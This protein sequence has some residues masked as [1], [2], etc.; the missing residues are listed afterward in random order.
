VPTLAVRALD[1]GEV[2][3]GPLVPPTRLT[4]PRDRPP[5]IFLLVR[6]LRL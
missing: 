5:P 4:P 2:G 6:S 1:V 3:G